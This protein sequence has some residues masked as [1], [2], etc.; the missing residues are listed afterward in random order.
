MI[1]SFL[2][3]ATA[4]ARLEIATAKAAFLIVRYPQL[5]RTVGLVGEVVEGGGC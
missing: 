2:F 4:V 5:F 3:L 1:W